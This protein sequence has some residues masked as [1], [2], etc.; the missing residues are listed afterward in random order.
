MHFYMFCE[1]NVTKVEWKFVLFI[2]YGK[3]SRNLTIQTQLKYKRYSSFSLEYS[4]GEINLCLA[5]TFFYFC[6]RNMNLHESPQ[7]NYNNYCTLNIL[8]VFAYYVHCVHL[9]TF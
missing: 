1:H 4:V 8:H 2:K 3:N 6:S 5:S 7:S 9:F